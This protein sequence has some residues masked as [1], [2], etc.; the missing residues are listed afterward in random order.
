MYVLTLL[1]GPRFSN[2][3]ELLFRAVK[4]GK[5]GAIKQ[6]AYV[7]ICNQHG[8]LIHYG[9]VYLVDGGDVD[10]YL[11]ILYCSTFVM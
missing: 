7:P 6:M 1:L 4:L 11:P 2:V 10:A 9:C 3:F 5:A 8:P